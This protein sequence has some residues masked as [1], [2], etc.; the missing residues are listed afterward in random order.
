MIMVGKDK[1]KVGTVSAVLRKENKVLVQG[2]NLVRTVIPIF[3]FFFDSLC[4]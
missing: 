2:L 4:L 3:Q 1:G